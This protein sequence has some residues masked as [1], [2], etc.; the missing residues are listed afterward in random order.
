MAEADQDERLAE[1]L[2][3]ESSGILN[4][5]LEGLQ[6]YFQN[7]LAATESMDR[8]TEDY[9]GQ[10]N[11]MERFVDE[12]CEIVAQETVR[13][14]SAEIYGRYKTW[15]DGNGEIAESSKAL[16]FYLKRKHKVVSFRTE[17]SKGLGKIRL[18][19]KPAVNLG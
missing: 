16:T 2:I 4:W 3:A 18:K 6:M 1:K 14:P 10:E 17:T 19:G 15:C 12:E 8:D 13:T 5:L 9:R 7:G 11:H